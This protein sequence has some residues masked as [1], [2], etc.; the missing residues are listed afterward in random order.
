MKKLI[1]SLTVITLFAACSQAPSFTVTGEL[2][3][4]EGTVYLTHK[5]DG[6]WANA[7]S[8]DLVEGKFTFNG[9]VAG[10]EQYLLTFKANKRVYVPF[11]LENSPIN[12]KA[13]LKNPAGNEI[14]GSA[15]Q[16]VMTK[17]GEAMKVFQE[18]EMELKK[19]YG[20]AVQAKDEEKM[21]KI[22]A[23]YNELQEEKATASKNFIRNNNKS[24]ASA[25]IASQMTQGKEADE[26]DELIALLD[27]SLLETDVVVGMKKKSR[28]FKKYCNRKDCS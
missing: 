1:I 5:V 14:T 3:G 7:D 27:A 25:F 19:A 8:A 28:W 10:P 24:F 17:Y 9:T 15:T 16:D 12:I 18:Q 2:T 21:K 20:S 26:I 13:D 4:I 23:D 22:V 11:F 6:A